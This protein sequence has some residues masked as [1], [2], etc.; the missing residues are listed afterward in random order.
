MGEARHFLAELSG[1]RG[2]H[3]RDAVAFIIS[4]EEERWRRAIEDARGQWGDSSFC[5]RITA[6][7]LE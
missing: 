3:T 7:L 1:W 2:E 5:L 6:L 4:Q